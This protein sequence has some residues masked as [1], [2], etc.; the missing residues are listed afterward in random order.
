M[1]FLLNEA[2]IYQAY[3]IVIIATFIPTLYAL[4]NP[5]VNGKVNLR[6]W[7]LMMKKDLLNFGYP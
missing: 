4:I 3:S 7:Y 1:N 5:L 2:I 6:Y